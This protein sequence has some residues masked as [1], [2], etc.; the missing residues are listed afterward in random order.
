MADKGIWWRSC[1]AC[2][3]K[4]FELSAGPLFCSN[5]HCKRGGR[6]MS[7]EETTDKQGQAQSVCI[8]DDCL[9]HRKGRYADDGSGDGGSWEI[10]VRPSTEKGSRRRS[11]RKTKGGSG[12]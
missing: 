10:P 12:V 3:G 7:F 6:I 4:L 5:E 1:Y 9:M 11:G 2:G 8:L